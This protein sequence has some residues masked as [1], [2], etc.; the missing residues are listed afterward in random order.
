VKGLVVKTDR[1]EG[2]QTVEYACPVRPDATKGIHRA[3]AHAIEQ[4]RN[5]AA[6]MPSGVLE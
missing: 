2:R 5:I 4:W 3:N 6:K 1:Q